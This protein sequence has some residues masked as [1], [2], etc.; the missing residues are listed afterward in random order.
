MLREG[1]RRKFE[2][3]PGIK[4]VGEAS[5]GAD[6]LKLLSEVPADAVIL[7]LRLGDMHGLTLLRTLTRDFPGCKAVILT[8]YDHVRFAIDS[9][10][11]GARAYVVK[12][13]PFDQLVRAIHEV[14]RN[15][16]FI[17]PPLRLK[18]DNWRR[19]MDRD[20]VGSLSPREL[21][22]LTHLAAGFSAK[23]VATRMGV[24]CKT[25]STYRTR[26]MAK[27]RVS[28]YAELMRVV[29][30]NGFTN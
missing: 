29:L 19:E 17:S 30:D 26:I 6:L 5:N 14:R 18:V 15:R 8:M 10:K 28:S 23:E 11:A 21:E 27:L 22:A 1:L 12:G 7:D 3:C 2:D 13:A 20:S 9:L 4:V 24:S 16:T 25:V